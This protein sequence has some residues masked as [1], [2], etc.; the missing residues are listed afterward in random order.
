MT[1]SLLY[2][3]EG[4]TAM[5]WKNGA[6]STLEIAQQRCVDDSGYDWRLSI[7]Q[8]N[9]D[10]A[11]SVFPGYSRIITVL[12]GD[13]MVLEVNGVD[14]E[15]LGPFKP[16]SFDG[17]ARV[18]CRLLGSAIEDFNLIYR[19][20]RVQ[21]SLRWVECHPAVVL[22]SAAAEVI[23]FNAASGV[24]KVTQAGDGRRHEL[25][26]RATLRCTNAGGQLQRYSLEGAAAQ[27]CVVELDKVG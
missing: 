11:F 13:G 20:D 21:A 4:Y 15:A 7:A 24:V 12:H 2:R 8:I 16:L 18:Q 26:S 22:A 3:P 25:G 19:K 1:D 27:V 17:G 23:F 9:A 6:G 5:P 14:S 10:G